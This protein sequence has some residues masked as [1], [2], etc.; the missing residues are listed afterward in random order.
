MK[1]ENREVMRNILYAVETGGQVYGGARYDDFTPAYT[2]S[3]IEHAIT[4]GAGA[5]YAMEAW[6]LLTLIRKNHPDKF[7][8]LDTAGIA[9]DLDAGQLAWGT[10]KAARGS[11]KAK[12]I[13]AIISSAEG[14]ACQDALMEQQIREYEKTITEKYGSMPDS[15]MMECINIIHQGGGS[16]LKRILGKTA[17]PYTAQSIYAALCTDPADK[18]NN[19]QVGDYVTRQKAVYAM[20]QKYCKEET[21]MTEREA[22]QKVV[23]AMNGWIGLKRPDRSHMVIIN[24][25][26]SCLPLARGYK[27]QPSDDYCATGASAAGIAAGFTDIIPRECS[28]GY[29]IELFQKM[30]RWVENDAYVPDQADF[31][32]Y[33]WKDGANYATTDCTGWPD[34]VGIV[35]E[36]NKNEGYLIVTECNMS[37][38]VVG[39]R[40][41]L[42]NGRYIRGYGIPDYASKAGTQTGT[43]AGTSSGASA[44][45][46]TSGGINKTARWV[47]QVTVN[48]L[49]VRTWAGDSY[50]KIKSWPTLGKDN[51]VDVC[52]TI[53]DANGHDWYYVKI[54]GK[55]YGFVD[56]SYVKKAT[57]SSEA[58]ENTSKPSYKV[59]QVYTL[60]VELKVR[61]APGA[62]SPTKSYSQ[63][64]ADGKR[65]DKDKDGCL[66][67]GTKVTCQDV[68]NDGSDIWIKAPSGWLAAYYEGHEYIK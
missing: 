66:D 68:T 44:G 58:A 28:C 10:Y 53:K 2:N 6:K 63:L 55:F 32:F 15:A 47:G 62:G 65:H 8:E 5:W 41:L 59:G 45:G 64:T 48:S 3:S 34:H 38:G 14:K 52:D 24:L 27:V 36:V 57:T 9:T 4:I 61:T 43:S 22:R 23:D 25:Y 40:K 37:G 54:A 30:G 16:A 49:P 35:A 51:L 39:Q 50:D 46:S 42:I 31:V 17:K 20:I 1:N 29:M 26:N 7:K 56:S 19:N 67:A 13:Q 33:Y 18:S 21:G 60:Q 12:C 11:A